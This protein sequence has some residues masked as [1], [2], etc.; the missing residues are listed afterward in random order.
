MGL[1]L[2]PD[3]FGSRPPSFLARK[4]SVLKEFTAKS[5]S[6]EATEYFFW[7]RSNDKVKAQRMG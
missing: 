1:Y 4:V 5:K 3:I 2:A 7:F 6:P